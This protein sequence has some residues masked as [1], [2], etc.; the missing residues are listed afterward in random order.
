MGIKNS[1]IFFLLLFLSISLG[2]LGQEGIT[3]N[4]TVSDASGPLPGV[5]ISV[6]GTSTGTTTDFDGNYTLRGVDPQATLVFSYVS[7]ST[8]EV[9]IN[10]RNTIDM[11]LEADAES[12]DDVVVVGYSTQSRAEVTGAISSISSEEIASVPVATADQALQGRAAGV[13]VVNSGAPGSAPVVRIRGLGTPNN[14]EPLYVIDGVISGGMGNLNPNDI[15]SIQVLKDAATTAV[16]GSK[17]SNGVV[18]ITT[19]TGSATGK[20]QLNFDSYSGVNFVSNRYDVL[21]ADQYI[22]Y[23]QEIGPT[24]PRLS[25]DQYAD[26]I[27][28]DTDW[29]DAIFRTGVMQSY[30]LSL[31]GGSENS[32][33]RFSGGYLG[34]EG[35]IIETKYERFNF[36]AN[37]NFTFGNLKIGETL[38]LSFDSQNPER[39][40]GGRTII[41]HAI[42]SAPYLP[43]YNAGNPGGFQG[44]SSAL[45]GQ[46]AENPVRVQTLGQA[47]NRSVNIIGSLYAEYSFWDKLTF[48][49]QV[50]LDYSNYKNTIFIPSFSDDETNTNSFDFAQITKN[51]GIYQSLTFTNSLR[52]KD[53]FNDVHNLEFLLLSEQQGIKNENINAYSQNPISNEVNQLSLV[54]ANLGS[55]SAEYNRIGYLGQVNYNFDRKYLFSASLRR[56]AS[57][58]FG[59]NNRWGW[60]PSLS[61]GWNIAKESFMEDT[62]FS[63]FKLRGSWGV[64][65][66]DNIGNYRYSSTLVTNFIYPIAGAPAT[67]TTASGLANPNLK[68][69]ETTMRNI[70]VDLGL[71]DNQFTASLEYYK[72]TSDDLLINRPLALSSGFNDPYITQ[73]IGSVETNGFEVSL[74]YNDYEGEFTWSANF[75]LGSSTNEVQS[76]GG[77]DFI[78]GGSFENENISRISVGEPLFYFYGLETNG[79]YQTQEEVDEVL[80][81]NPE[82]TTVQPG[83]IRFVD[84]NGDGMISSADKT[85]IGNP[86]PDFTYG[87]NL[88]AN[89]KDFDFSLFINGSQGNDIYNTNI[90]DL[91]G[92]TRLFNAGTDVLDRW[93]GPGTSNYIPRA[94]GA[95][96]NTAA[97]D[98]FVE[99]GSFTR[100]RNLVVGYT[101]PKNMFNDYLSKFRIY[102]SGQNLVTITDYSGLDPEIG[103]PALSGNEDTQRFEVGIDRGNYPQPQSVLVGLQLA[104]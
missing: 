14:N 100:L 97:S 43:I 40:S 39:T 21:N 93:T 30:N 11:V 42:K 17:G 36:R 65:G 81:A 35:A 5:N 86:Y 31:A 61:A 68:W 90:Y 18:V 27:D 66:N 77:V 25:E 95:T 28:N 87:L 55:A 34:Q 60:F 70:G 83:D 3:V 29:Q 64:T 44:P 92:M 20:A 41:E 13:N 1:K 22:Q 75:N 78:E 101:F 26:F 9:Q 71:L 59:E 12:L 7:Y 91:Q 94:I 48:K 45:D 16:Y 19:K 63:N 49:T 46:D 37:S 47:E 104:F 85:K 103:V 67:G 89:Y 62:A 50:G 33:F 79:I 32:N 8:E 24:P 6:K 80:T 53:T 54:G 102:L 74:G 72:N 73:N 58:R 4:G 98:R 82:Q 2:A 56:D 96:Q 69:E 88:S 38:G 52:Y 23:A 99:D 10:G 84:R 15:K 57:S 51:T 76:L